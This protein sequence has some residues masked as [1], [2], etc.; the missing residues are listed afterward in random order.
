MS[1]CCCY[2]LIGK[3]EKGTALLKLI[4]NDKTSHADQMVVS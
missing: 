1:T 4:G 3:R 2:I